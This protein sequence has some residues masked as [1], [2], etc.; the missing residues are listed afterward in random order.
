MNGNVWIENT[1]KSGKDEETHVDWEVGQGMNLL[2][3]PPI[4]IEVEASVTPKE[5]LIYQ[6]F[7]R[8]LLCSERQQSNEYSLKADIF[9]LINGAH[10]INFLF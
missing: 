10:L 1:I 8:T 5:T 9:K 6:V 3:S 4:L 7:S 2:L